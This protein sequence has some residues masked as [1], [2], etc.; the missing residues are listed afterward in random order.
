MNGL[1]HRI[2]FLF[3]ILLF[4]LSVMAE[5]SRKNSSYGPDG[6]R[7]GLGVILGDPTGLSGKGYLSSDDAIHGIASWSFVD[8]AFTLIGDFTHDFVE[9]PVD[10][11]VLTIPFYAGVGGKLV[12]NKGRPAGDKT[13]GGIRV[14]VGVALQWQ[15]HPVELFIEAAPGIELAPETEFDLT[16]GVGAHFYF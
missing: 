9:I 16:G 5:E 15:R 11:S 2:S 14:P 6:K 10:T 8:D 1:I 4:S 7:F 13:A 3:V 12:V